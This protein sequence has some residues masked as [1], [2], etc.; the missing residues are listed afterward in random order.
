MPLIYFTYPYFYKRLFEHGNRIVLLN[1][2]YIVFVRSTSQ[3][4]SILFYSIIPS[5]PT[6]DVIHIV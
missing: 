3:V 6:V 4:Y 1:I 2:V 5:L